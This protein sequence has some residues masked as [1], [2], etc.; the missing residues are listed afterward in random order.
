MIVSDERSER[1]ARHSGSLSDRCISPGVAKDGPEAKTLTIRALSMDYK[2]KN[3]KKC[4]LL[5]LTVIPSATEFA[6]R[7]G[8][9]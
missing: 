7:A 4:L 3:H 2:Y 5:M 9:K 8:K 6:S 1:E